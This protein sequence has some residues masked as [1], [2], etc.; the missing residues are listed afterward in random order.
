MTLIMSG[1]NAL[2]ACYKRV[3]GVFPGHL[4]TFE[5]EV[6]TEEMTSTELV[7][8]FEIQFDYILSESSE[9][10]EIKKMRDASTLG[11]PFMLIFESLTKISSCAFNR[12]GAA[13]GEAN[14]RHSG[15]T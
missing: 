2:T 15:C 12:G 5:V 8:E 7:F 6:E 4:Y 13:V 14:G 10:W 9:A 1:G 3:Q 11:G